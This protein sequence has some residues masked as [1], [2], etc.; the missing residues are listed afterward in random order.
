M[1]EQ[2]DDSKKRLSLREIVGS[3][4]FLKGG[5]TE[6]VEIII[7]LIVLLIFGLIAIKTI[8]GHGILLIGENKQD[9]TPTYAFC[10]DDLSKIEK[11]KFF[12]LRIKRK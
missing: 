2:E 10:I 5:E 4:F 9:G 1:A 11:K 3:F 7:L 8:P 12:I 6:M